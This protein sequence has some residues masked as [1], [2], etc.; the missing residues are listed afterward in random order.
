MHEKYVAEKYKASVAIAIK[1]LENSYK[2]YQTNPE[3]HP[4]YSDEW[5][6]FWSRRYNELKAQ[7][8]NA[9]DHDYKPEWVEFWTRKVKELLRIDIN[10]KKEITR[11][12][13]GLSIEDVMK[14]ENE[15]PNETTSQTKKIS[16]SQKKRTKSPIEISDD[17]DDNERRAPKKS[18]FERS[19]QL[20]KQSQSRSY[21]DRVYSNHSDSHR[22]YKNYNTSRFRARDANSPESYVDT[23]VNLISVCRL[24][25]ALESELGI[26]ATAVIDLLSRAI[27]LEKVKPNSADELLLTPDNCIMLETVKEKLKGILMANLVETNKKNAVKRGVQN[28]A[29]LL[30][31]ASKKKNILNGEIASTSNLPDETELAVTARFQIAALI[32]QTLIEQGNTNVSSAELE[33]LVDSIIYSKKEEIQAVEDRKSTSAASTSENFNQNTTKSVESLTD[34]DLQTLLQNF[35][36]LTSE[37]QTSLISYLTKVEQTDPSRIEKLRNYLPVFKSPETQN[38]FSDDDF[39]DDS[40]ARQLGSNS[41]VQNFY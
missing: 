29:I 28:I 30:H 25:S 33:A 2:E 20:E 36:E 6:S 35:T 8:K 24:L 27:A 9:N 31:E 39:D 3:N 23:P 38:Q 5:K 4:N 14:I 19:P 13:L 10:K 34:N 15:K 41:S 1:Q 12:D 18:R 21:D 7:G 37:E 11:K 16:V 40:L 32:T 26:M 22:D 17:S